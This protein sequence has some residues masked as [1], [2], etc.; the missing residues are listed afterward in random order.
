MDNTTN[1]SRVQ[2]QMGIF[3]IELGLA[4]DI[5]DLD[6]E[7][8]S[9]ETYDEVALN[10]SGR[11]TSDPDDDRPPTLTPNK[12]MRCNDKHIF[13]T[14]NARTLAPAGRLDE[15]LFCCEQYSIEILAIQEHRFY[16]PDERKQTTIIGNHQLIT[17]SC[18][19][20]SVNASIGGYWCFT[21]P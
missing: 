4:P 12:I 1:S 9:P 7:I 14:F 5:I 11:A 17:S 3:P 20:N 8:V 2:V 16:H 19:K 13:S 18:W 15:L 10:L 6:S 21:L